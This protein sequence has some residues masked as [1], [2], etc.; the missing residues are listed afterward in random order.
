MT[1]R[2]GTC[3]V[4]TLLVERTRGQAS[5][6]RVSLASR[7]HA[8]DIGDIPDAVAR[9]QFRKAFGDPPHDAWALIDQRG[10]KLH[11]RCAEADFGIGVFGAGYAAGADQHMALAVHAAEGLADAEIGERRRRRT[12]HR[13]RHLAPDFF[14]RSHSLRL[15]R[16]QVEHEAGDKISGIGGREHAFDRLD[17][18]ER[19]DLEKHRPAQFHLVKRA[20]AGVE[21]PGSRRRNRGRRPCWGMTDS[22]SGNRHAAP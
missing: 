13:A 2:N 12:G 1:V 10:Q 8:D 22:A 14:R 7:I 19:R 15:H 9:Q 5:Q 18:A 4:P 3:G 20:Q 21:M 16:R 17:A 11:Q 6:N